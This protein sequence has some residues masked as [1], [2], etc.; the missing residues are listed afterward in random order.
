M[1]TPST[2]GQL[3]ETATLVL[4]YPAGTQGHSRGASPSAMSGTG[5]PK[6]TL[7]LQQG[8]PWA[9]LWGY[10]EE[11]LVTTR[12]PLNLLLSKLNKSRDTPQETVLQQFKIYITLETFFSAAH[13]RFS[14]DWENGK[15]S[16]QQKCLQFASYHM[17][18]V[19]LTGKPSHKVSMG[20]QEHSMQSRWDPSLCQWGQQCPW[21][22][23]CL[24]WLWVHPP[25]GPRWNLFPSAVSGLSVARGK[26]G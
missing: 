19:L 3:L 14:R 11:L 22:M 25:M 6:V 17:L 2:P 18:P 7:R 26:N 5:F 13:E 1:T 4:R 23:G 24:P 21:G 16:K 15:E 20:S 8:F 10:A 12:P 9:V